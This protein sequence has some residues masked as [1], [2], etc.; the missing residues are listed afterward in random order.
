MPVIVLLWKASAGSSLVN[1]DRISRANT[2]LVL[3]PLSTLRLQLLQIVVLV[4]IIYRGRFNV[5]LS[6]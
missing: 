5:H 1:F 2:Q 3:G 4:N 6:G